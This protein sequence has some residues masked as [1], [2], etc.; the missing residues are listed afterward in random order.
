LFV[1]RLGLKLYK[2][3]LWREACLGKRYQRIPYGAWNT[4]SQVQFVEKQPD[5][6]DKQG[7]TIVIIRMDSRPM[8]WRD[9]K[10]TKVGKMALISQVQQQKYK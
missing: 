4:L 6:A 5:A 7:L 10:L 1:E 9:V 2:S 3:D 8:R